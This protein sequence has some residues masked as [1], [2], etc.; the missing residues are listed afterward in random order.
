[1]ARIQSIF[2]STEAS[3]KLFQTSISAGDANGLDGIL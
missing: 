3:R 2:V 1:M